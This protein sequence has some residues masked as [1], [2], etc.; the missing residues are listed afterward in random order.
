MKT[1]FLAAAAALVA[2]V[3]AQAQ[4]PEPAPAPTPETFYF[5]GCGDTPLTNATAA[6][7]TWSAT[8]PTG[9]LADGD[10]CVS[11][12]PYF[13]DAVFGG[14]YG[15]EVKQFDLTLY[16]VASNPLYRQVALPVSIDLSV[17]VG[18]REVYFGEDL[19]VPAEADGDLPGGFKAT[20]TIPELDIPATAT[21]KP[22][23]VTV[24]THFSDDPFFWG[25]GAGDVPSSITFYDAAD[26]PEPAPEEE[27]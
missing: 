6:E 19:Q 14:A 4:T 15:G 1:F 3:P 11:F 22:Y 9:S 5:G 25:R 8:A 17:T 23:V 27:L 24:T 21:P 18:G 2:V 7:P 26:L 12:A 20:W 13:E 16:N 10:G